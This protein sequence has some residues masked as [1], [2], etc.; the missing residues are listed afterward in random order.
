MQEKPSVTGSMYTKV[1]QNMQEKERWKNNEDKKNEQA[2]FCIAWKYD[3]NNIADITDK[4]NSENV[5]IIYRW[6]TYEICIVRL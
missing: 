1:C 2:V 6:C 3:R 5:T 4:S